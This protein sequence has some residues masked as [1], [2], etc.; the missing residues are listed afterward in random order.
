MF[1]REETKVNIDL[2]SSSK[3]FGNRLCGHLST[4][5]RNKTSH[6]PK[7][8]HPTAS[9]TRL[10]APHSR[11]RCAGPGTPRAQT[12]RSEGWIT[13]AA[14]GDTTNEATLRLTATID[15]HSVIQNSSH[16]E[17]GMGSGACAF[18]PNVHSL[19][20]ALPAAAG[21]H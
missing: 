12:R 4:P 15:T 13:A 16:A 10:Q 3:R 6:K 17:L 2:P 9:V 5:S 21:S 18:T 7:I 20:K 19:A 11:L 8:H 14:A 1:A